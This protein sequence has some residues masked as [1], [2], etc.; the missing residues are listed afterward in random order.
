VQF[1]GNA[2]RA[3]YAVSAAALLDISRGELWTGRHCI[4]FR[5]LIRGVEPAVSRLLIRG[6]GGKYRQLPPGRQETADSRRR[7]AVETGNFRQ[8]PCSGGLRTVARPRGEKLPVNRQRNAPGALPCAA[9][10][11]AAILTLA[12]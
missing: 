8:L 4:R 10:E 9:D 12:A 11:A 6:P 3:E 1:A 5:R 2:S 7:L